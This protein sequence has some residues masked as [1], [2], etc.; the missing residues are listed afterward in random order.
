MIG[1]TEADGLPN[2]A[3]MTADRLSLSMRW[4]GN[5]EPKKLTV[6][7]FTD[8]LI[9]TMRSR[10]RRPKQIRPARVCEEVRGRYST[11]SQRRET[12]HAP[13]MSKE[14]RASQDQR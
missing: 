11:L 5:R 4:A 8:T 3:E 9:S 1:G 13:R 12:V 10:T 7:I 2:E 6:E 14:G